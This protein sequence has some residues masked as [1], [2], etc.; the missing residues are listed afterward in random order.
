MRS[1][2]LTVTLLAVTFAAA[3]FA[4]NWTVVAS[5]DGPYPSNGY[6]I[7][8]YGNYLYCIAGPGSSSV[9]VITT[10][11]SLV[12]TIPV[13]TS[14]YDV[15]FNGTYFWVAHTD[16]YCR[17]YTS[18]GSILSSFSLGS[19]TGH[20]VAYDGTYIWLKGDTAPSTEYIYRMST[21]GAIYSSFSC[22]FYGD[23][24][25]DYAA[26]YLWF[27]NASTIYKTNTTGS[28][29]D[30]FASPCTYAYGASWDGTYFW[31]TNN[32]GGW[33]YKMQDV[34]NVAPASFG[35]VK[36]VYR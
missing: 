21:T 31:T 33:V 9:Y 22:P 10:T 23:G 28:I 11:G 36:A 12:N 32:T 29:A 17:R 3:S 15:D 18:T 35:K 16:H 20:G 6:G 24:A 7:E 14:G 26:N 5:F 8:A 34:E 25:I 13:L 1:F 27:S 2:A 4:S 30:S 19:I